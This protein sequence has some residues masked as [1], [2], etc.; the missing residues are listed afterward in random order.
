[1]K[2]GTVVSLNPNPKSQSGL[3]LRKETSAEVK[4]AK[5]YFFAKHFKFYFILNISFN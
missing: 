5:F 3:K 4:I 1:M 2:I